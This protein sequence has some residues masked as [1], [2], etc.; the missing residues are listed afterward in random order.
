L[1]EQSKYSVV[2]LATRAD[3]LDADVVENVTVKHSQSGVKVLAAPNKPEQADTVSGEQ[4][5]KMLRYLKTVYSY[6]IVDTTSSLQEITLA[7]IDAAD[8]LVL[9]TTQDIPSIKSCRLF[10]DVANAFGMDRSRIVFVMNKFDKRIGITPEKV[11]DNLK[12][13]ILAVIPFEERVIV[14]VN[15]GIPFLIADKTRPLSRAILSLAEVI[16]KKVLEQETQTEQVSS[17]RKIGKR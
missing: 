3:E 4:F 11:G 5:G 6:V 12:Q 7:A 8:I 16:R 1:N 17:L 2:D 15:K 14:S 10:L 9:V 13:E